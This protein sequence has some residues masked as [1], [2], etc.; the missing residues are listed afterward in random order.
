V[1][2]WNTGR[3]NPMTKRNAA[4]IAGHGVPAV[5][6]IFWVLSVITHAGAYVGRGNDV[7]FVALDEARFEFCWDLVESGDGPWDR[8]GFHRVPGPSP[9]GDLRILAPF[10]GEVEDLPSFVRVS[11]PLWAIAGVAAVW[12]G[13]A[14]F[15]YGRGQG[16]GN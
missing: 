10:E 6:V 13:L 14:V 1:V 5:A 7:I 15:R 9:H 8:R 3:W 2:R 16:A 12:G 11:L 4:R